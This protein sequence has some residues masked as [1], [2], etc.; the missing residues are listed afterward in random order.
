[1]PAPLEVFATGTGIAYLAVT[2]TAD[3]A[4]N[5]AVPGA[6]VK[7]GVAGAQDY[8]EDGIVIQ[9]STDE[10]KIYTAGQYGVRKVFRTREDLTVKLTVYDLTLEALAAAF[11][12]TAITTVVGPP[13]I[14]TIPLLEDAAVPV[15]RTMLIRVPGLSPYM[16]GGVLQIWIP[17]VYQTGATAIA[18]KK[19]DP[20]GLQME[21]TAVADATYG[22]GKVTAQTA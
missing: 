13:A 18:L 15:Y 17:L 21:F 5:A 4:V 9:K 7:L 16:D 10:N 22:F 11:N 14:K 20:A 19:A 8:S 6:F 3:P 1:M 2:G 12:Q